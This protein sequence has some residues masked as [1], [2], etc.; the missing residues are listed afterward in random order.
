MNRCIFKRLHRSAVK[1]MV[2][3]LFFACSSQPVNPFSTESEMRLL[4]SVSAKRQPAVYA[5]D[6]T[7]VVAGPKDLSFRELASILTENRFTSIEALL[8]HLAKTK[9]E[10]LSHYALGF[11]SRSLHESSP[12]APRA[13]VYGQ[14]G[15]FM[16]SLKWG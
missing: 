16:I 12:Q 2:L 11:A 13:I 8:R 5:A 14:Q 4:V 1:F 15:E 3:I 6:L 7:K 10:Y 9:P